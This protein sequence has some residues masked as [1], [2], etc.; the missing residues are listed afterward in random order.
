MGATDDGTPS[1]ITVDDQLLKTLADI[2]DQGKILPAPSMSVEK[3][4]LR[5]ADMAV[6]RVYPSDA[7]PVRYEGRIWVRIGPRRGIATAQRALSEN[8]NPPAEFVVEPN[9]VPVTMR[10]RP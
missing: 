7:P 9:F 10:N 8:G 5:G 2:R 4:H 6:V 1:G 3:R